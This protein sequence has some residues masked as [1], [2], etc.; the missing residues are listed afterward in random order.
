MTLLTTYTE[1]SVT[2]SQESITPILDRNSNLFAPL[3]LFFSC[4]LVTV[5]SNLSENQCLVEYLIRSKHHL[6]EALDA[7]NISIGVSYRCKS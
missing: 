4:S 5:V 6:F 1:R 2:S 3:V 7:Q